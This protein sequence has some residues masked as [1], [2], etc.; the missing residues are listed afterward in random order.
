MS[1]PACA[2]HTVR[3]STLFAVPSA[4]PPQTSHG[5]ADVFVGGSGSTFVDTHSRPAS[6]TSGSWLTQGQ[7]DGQVAVRVHR[8]VAVRAAGF[9]AIPEGAVAPDPT[10]LERPSKV[11]FGAGPIVSVGH[12]AED[13]PF[14]ARVE[15]GLIFGFFPSVLLVT[16]EESW[17]S[18]CPCPTRR[19]EHL[20]LMPIVHGGLSAGYWVTDFL[21]LSGG[22]VLRNQ[23]RSAFRGEFSVGP[24]SGEARIDFGDLAGI[25]WVAAELEIER[26]VGI[27]AQVQL[28][29]LG[30]QLFGPTLSIGVRGVIGTGP[31]TVPEMTEPE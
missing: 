28:P 21:A 16:R 27:V 3:Q 11:A 19:E 10:T 7:L 13:D 31:R 12:A 8:V 17:W 14:F 30:D 23:P 2:T 5:R 4:G 20:G 6:E 9:V 29:I 1:L 18:S 24:R 15:A 26:M 22:I 25:P